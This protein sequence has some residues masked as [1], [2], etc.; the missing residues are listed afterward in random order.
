MKVGDCVKV[1][2]VDN[3]DWTHKW[4]G[5]CVWTDG[6]KGEFLIDGELETWTCGDLE[7]LGAEVINENR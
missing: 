2:G 4:I 7:I 3:S 1:D 5:I 6:Y